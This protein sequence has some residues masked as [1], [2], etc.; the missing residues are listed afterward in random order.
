MEEAIAL[1]EFVN[2][3]PN[4]NVL[5]EIAERRLLDLQNGAQ[6]SIEGLTERRAYSPRKRYN[7]RVRR[8]LPKILYKVQP[9]LR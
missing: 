8:I 1:I 3:R 4:G 2:A 5:R 6:R 9:R 7:T